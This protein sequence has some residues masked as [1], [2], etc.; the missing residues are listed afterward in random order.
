MWIKCNNKLLL[1]NMLR[2]KSLIENT[3]TNNVI[4]N[5][6]DLQNVANTYFSN[7]IDLNVYHI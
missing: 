2:G 4:R 1:P 7:P 6:N 5:H 3:K